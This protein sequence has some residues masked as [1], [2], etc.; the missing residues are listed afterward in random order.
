MEVFDNL[1]NAPRRSHAIVF[2][3]AFIDEVNDQYAIFLEWQEE[4]ENE[5]PAVECFNCG[6]NVE[7]MTDGGY[8]IC[9]KC[10]AMLKPVEIQIGEDSV[11]SCGEGETGCKC[12]GC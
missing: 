2:R 12:N 7:L 3:E 9:L 10:I 1:T 11:P 8:Y 4:N 5:P 6:S